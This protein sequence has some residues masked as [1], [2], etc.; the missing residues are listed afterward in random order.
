MPDLTR[1]PIQRW[2]PLAILSNTGPGTRK[3]DSEQW[4]TLQLPESASTDAVLP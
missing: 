2:R 1:D 3:T 4:K